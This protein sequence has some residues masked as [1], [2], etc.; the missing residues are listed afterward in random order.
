MPLD[1]TTLFA[2][3][4]WTV[5]VAVAT[6]LVV[7][8]WYRAGL[9]RL[10]QR[11]LRLRDNPSLVVFEG[12]LGKKRSPLR[13]IAEPL[14]DLL[15]SYRHALAQ[16]VDTQ[17]QIESLRR[18]LNVDSSEMPA[19]STSER[20]R[21]GMQGSS[22]SMQDPAGRR[23]VA[24]LTPNLFW[25]AATTTLQELLGQSIESLQA[26]SF[27]QFVH[28]Q[29]VARVE[30][31]IAEAFKEGEVHNI[32]FRLLR[33]EN[34]QA[35][36]G[37]T[38]EAKEPPEERHIQMHVMACKDAEEEP[39]NLR[40]HF[41]DITDRVLTERE[42]R[43]RTVQLVQANERLRQI[44]TDL[45][46]LKESYRDLYH[47]APVMYFS[48]DEKGCFA[49]CNDTLLRTLG[50]RREELLGRPYS[51]LLTEA[52]RP[53]YEA[54]AGQLQRPGEIETQWQPRDGSVIDVWIGTTVIKNRQ[55]QFIRSR[56][57]ARDISERNHL[58]RAVAGRARELEQANGQLLRINQE[59]EEFTY[60]VSHDLKEPLRT[61]EAFSTFL[62]ADYSDHLGMQGQEYIQHLIG[63]SRRLA[64]LIDDLL[65]LSRAGKVLGAPRLL[66]WDFI[67]ATVQ[68]D[69]RDLLQR[70]N[71]TIRIE[72][73]F[74]PA[75]GDPERIIQLLTNLMSNGLKYN[76]EAVPEVVI[77]A[78]GVLDG[79]VPAGMGSP[80]PHGRDRKPARWALFWVRDN[81]IGIEPQ[82]HDQIFRIFRR[83]HRRE[84]Y[85]GTGA[86][87]AICKKIV[88]AHEGRIWV[89][90][91]P[92][93]GATF[94]FTLPSPAP[95]DR[96]AGGRTSAG[97]QP[98][99][100]LSDR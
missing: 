29:D 28:P 12:T 45:E 10:G 34:R 47:Q 80:S 4:T 15:G 2:L 94:F 5:A 37:D 75:L 22:V 20:L 86:G 23:M 27:L 50:C 8:I 93:K 77:G 43:R 19:L 40:C 72:G 62:A 76:T 92:G 39:L 61:L 32:T 30:A 88:E 36:T 24:R 98:A 60:V 9:R 55:G 99:A 13:E 85:E 3:G 11:V 89:E 41:L 35:A 51:H 96:R 58:T 100:L 91:Q 38:G 97:G 53:A 65:C 48:L 69:L 79:P 1:S 31:Q 70:R 57:A 6:A 95:F 78:S 68:G 67:L 63:A 46:R 25:Q 82:Y 71:A 26:Q 21:T 81:G 84:E 33:T 56:S 52:A 87:L 14:E 83:L 16:V 64:R 17:T 59:L 54:D 73:T 66:D 49:A 44:N 90:S 42:L 74:P 7:R 18:R